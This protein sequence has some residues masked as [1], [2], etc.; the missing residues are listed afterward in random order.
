LC[1]EREYLPDVWIVLPKDVHLNN[2]V[3]EQGEDGELKDSPEESK[4]ENVNEV[5]EELLP[6]HVVA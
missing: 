5:V 3:G 2:D 6:L 4:N 1:Y